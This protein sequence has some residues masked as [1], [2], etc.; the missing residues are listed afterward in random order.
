MLSTSDHCCYDGSVRTTITLD[1]DVAALLARVRSDRS[2]GLKDAVNEG[3]RHGLRQ[4]IA[5]PAKREPYRTPVA[6]VG[7]FLLADVDDIAEALALVEGDA[8]R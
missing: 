3:L 4:L 6:S 1:D 5:P 7:R 2:L 8:F